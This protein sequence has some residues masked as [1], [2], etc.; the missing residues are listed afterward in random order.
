MNFEEKVRNRELS[1]GLLRQRRNLLVSSVAVFI[2]IALGFELTELRF[3]GNIAKV[4]NPHAV[5]IL[6]FVAHIYFTLRYWQYYL[7]ENPIP[8]ILD[9]LVSNIRDCEGKLLDSKAKSSLTVL[10]PFKHFNLSYPR[11]GRL[12]WGEPHQVITDKWVNPVYKSICVHAQIYSEDRLAVFDE[13]GDEY[14]FKDEY[15]SQKEWKFVK[16]TEDHWGTPQGIIIEGWVTCPRLLFPWF[17]L[18]AIAK[19]IF[20]QSYFTDY[21]L[22]LVLSC[23]SLVFSCVS[24]LKV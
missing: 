6:L 9:V 21:Q 19:Y 15:S 8:K 12:T 2:F 22:P 1:A 13:T 20:V 17:K 10:F 18:K 5:P 16:K 11:Y 23:I 4:N 3:L 24:Y 7:E 14:F